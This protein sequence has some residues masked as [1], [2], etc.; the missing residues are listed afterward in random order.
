MRS[1]HFFPFVLLLIVFIAFGMLT[2]WLGFQG[3][4]WHLI[5]LQYRIGSLSPF[6]NLTRFSTQWIYQLIMP[7]LAPAPWQWFLL[8]ILFRLASGIIIFLLFMGLFPEQKEH[9]GL[10]ALLYCLYPG[11]LISYLPLTFLAQFIQPFCLFLSF[12]LM[13][14][15][16]EAKTRKGWLLGLSL[17]ASLANLLLSEYFFFLELLR[18]L[19]IWRVLQRTQKKRILA[20][21]VLKR[22]LYFLG[23][24]IFILVVRIITQILGTGKAI[25]T[26]NK[27]TLQPGPAISQLLQQI[28]HDFYT[29]IIQPFTASLTPKI[30]PSSPQGKFFFMGSLLVGLIIFVY[31][32]R[33]RSLENKQRIKILPVL[34]L[35][36]LAF[37]L[38]GVP[39]WMAGLQPI[40]GFE[41]KNRYALTQAL[42]FSIFLFVF[43]NLIPYRWR[44]LQ[45]ILIALLAGLFAGAQLQSAALVRAEWDQQ[46]WLFWQFA[47]RAPQLERGSVILMNDPGF[48]LSGENSVSA[49]LNWNYADEI[50]PQQSEY[51]LY[52]DEH[53]F[54]SDFPDFP[55]NKSVNIPH[56]LGTV[57]VNPSQL[58]VLHFSSSGCLRFLD[59]QIDELDGTITDFTHKYVR[60]SNLSVIQA[61]SPLDSRK[62]DPA[63]FWDEPEHGWCYFFQKADLARQLGDWQAVVENAELA[64]AQMPSTYDHVE[65]RPYIEG[66]AH[67]NDWLRAIQLTENILT[68]STGTNRLMCALWQRIA[69]STPTSSQKN[70]ALA[71][72]TSQT[73]CNF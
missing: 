62:L 34:G 58:I 49:E 73:G 21:S 54:L 32:L 55:T 23:V 14:L 26:F 29:V 5:W 9:A 72:M 24:F 35:G 2:P 59:P 61:A 43:L 37:L 18:P 68:S 3:D 13:V 36:L 57:K 63:I 16:M 6:F 60:F 27:F 64:V 28:F 25:A 19:I 52:F 31:L 45:A 1:Q 44:V 4:D 65:I 47:W 39:F 41:M 71:W 51:F 56:M 11:Y 46:R 8:T 48:Q 22:W 30:D 20:S 38:A 12:Y 69:G 53:R 15:W 70:N 33:E 42:S 40:F 66:Y 50:H 17:A 7:W 67:T 10:F